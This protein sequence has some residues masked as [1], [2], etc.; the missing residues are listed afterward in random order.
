MPWSGSLFHE[1]DEPLR[2][3]VLTRFQTESRFHT[4]C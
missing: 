4:L 1:N 2:L 3:L